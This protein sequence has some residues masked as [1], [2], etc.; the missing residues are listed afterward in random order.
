ML[1]QV[2]EII[3]SQLNIEKSTLNME[4]NLKKDLDI[5]SGSVLELVFTIE[6]KFNIELPDD[7]V[8][9]INTIGDVVNFIE[10]K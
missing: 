2:I 1:E 10:K 4:T 6:D 5:D 8:D 9:K 3:A 7:I